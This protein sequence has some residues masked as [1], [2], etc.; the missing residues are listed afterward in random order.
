MAMRKQ[1]GREWIQVKR[2]DLLYPIII[3]IILAAFAISA[4]AWPELFD[5]LA[6][7]LKEAIRMYVGF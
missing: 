5:R 2:E 6:G 1:H 3:P 4:S 7:S